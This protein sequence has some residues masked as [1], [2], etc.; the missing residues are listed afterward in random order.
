VRGSTP[1]V[2]K[3]YERYGGNTSCIAVLNQQGPP[4]LILDAGTGLRSTSDLMNGRPFQGTILLGHLHWDHTHGLPFTGCV[5]RPDAV[6]RL[7]QPEQGPAEQVLARAISPPHFPVRPSQLAGEWTFD[8]IDPGEHQIEGLQVRAVEIPHPGGRMFG[9]RVSDGRRT[10][11]YV[12]DHSPIDFGAGPAGWGEY[13][14][15]IRELATGVDLLIHDAQYTADE[16]PSRRTYGHSTFDYT[17]G[18]AREC[19][20]PRLTT[21]WIRSWRSSPRPWKAG[22][23]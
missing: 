23:S 5:N 4:Q 3:E 20:V 17:V 16:F 8:S 7:V 19:Q 18:L 15:A 11:A 21:S 12:S 22:S 13:H 9:Y 2:G 1:A 14:P 10:F 6:V